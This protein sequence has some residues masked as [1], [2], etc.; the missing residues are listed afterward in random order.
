MAWL[1][2]SSGDWSLSYSVGDKY[3]PDSKTAGIAALDAEV[4]GEGTYTVS[5]DFTG[6]GGGYAGGMVFAALAVANGEQLF[7]GYVVTIT[8]VLINDEPIEWEGTAYTTSDDGQCTRVNLYNTWVSDVPAEARI[9]EG[10]RASATPVPLS[11]Y[12][13]EQIKTITVT[14]NYAGA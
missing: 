7:P 6:T 3:D 12:A 11:A 5:L 14:F 13:E 10:G 9:A 2:F 1:M 4:T 8:E